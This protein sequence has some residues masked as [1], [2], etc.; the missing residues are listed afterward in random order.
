[1]TK[2]PVLISLALLLGACD[3]DGTPA[4]AQDTVGVV[5]DASHAGDVSGQ[6]DAGGDAAEAG[7]SSD[8]GCSDLRFPG[9]FKDPNDECWDPPLHYCSAGYAGSETACTPDGTLCCG[10]FSGC[11]PC[12]WVPCGTPAG[13]PANP[14]CPLASELADRPECLPY[15]Y[16][17]D[18]PICWDDVERR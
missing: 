17:L 1:L 4:G 2:A 12:G 9:D 10:F 18:M 6:P 14:E 8:G 16:D 11:A 5:K 7:A 13:D 15:K 3:E